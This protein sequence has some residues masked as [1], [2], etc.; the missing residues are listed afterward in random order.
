MDVVFRV[1]AV[2]NIGMGH[3]MRC[4]ALSEEIIRNGGTCY[5]ISKINSPVLKNKVKNTG[6]ILEDVDRK[7]SWDE[8]CEFV[9]NF[10]KKKG[11]NWVVT[12]HYGIT[13]EYIKN[14]K[15]E[16]LFVLSI[17]D[18]ANIVYYSDI[19]V[20]Q[21]VGA[22]KL[23]IKKDGKTK[24]LLGPKYLILRDE[25]LSA[26]RK[27]PKDV[28]KNILVTLGGSDKN[29][30]TAK[31]VE[32]LKNKNR[33]ITYTIVV[34]PLN[35]KKISDEN[36]EL[37]HSPKNMAKIYSKS[38]IAIS[39]GG[40]TCYELLFFGIPN[41]IVAI[42]KNQIN[43]AKNLDKLKTSVFIGERDK[44]NFEEIVYKIELL[45]RN[46]KLRKKMAKKGM[47]IIDGKGK[48]RII[49]E[50]NKIK[51]IKLRK[52]T[53]ADSELL[54][55]WR[56][57]KSVRES[58][59]SSEKIEYSSHEEWYKNKLKNPNT[60]FFIATDSSNKPVGQIRFDKINK[61]VF[62]VDVSVDKNNTNK[63]YGS[64]IIKEGCHILSD[65]VK[66]KK[67]ISRIKKNNV[68]SIKAFS[69]AGFKIIKKET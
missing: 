18:T 28:V 44:I 53:M 50:M 16:G 35:D 34:G 52:A 65:N 59:F 27:K 20:N 37:L 60:Y 7:I 62:E 11:I 8:D 64:L 49:E 4:I 33:D 67:I 45:R 3:L 14:L 57:Q 10:C 26:P 46:K 12:D 22:E 38:D 24:L 66:I 23:D 19:V 63:G 43:I 39:S 58:A 32:S 5:F 29:D 13:E 48:I 68:K 1:D 21:N 42:A 41:I 47:E 54:W 55:N 36:T 31:I 69:N 17:D 51:L 56:N 9:A 6:I 30:V 25:L 61:D 40:T 15:E 2:K